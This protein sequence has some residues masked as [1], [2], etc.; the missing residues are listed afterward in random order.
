MTYTF[1]VGIMTLL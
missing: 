1:Y